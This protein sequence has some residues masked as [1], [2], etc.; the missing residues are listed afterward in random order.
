MS[1]HGR[2]NAARIHSYLSIEIHVVFS[3]A[4]SLSFWTFSQGIEILRVQF[5]FEE[6]P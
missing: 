4:K 3:I 1:K 2:V 5:H 6:R